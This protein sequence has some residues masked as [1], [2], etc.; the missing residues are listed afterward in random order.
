MWVQFPPGTLNLFHLFL[1]IFAKKTSKTYNTNILF[2]IHLLSII[3]YMDS[4]KLKEM[5]AQAAIEHIQK[6]DKK[7]VL[8]I[9]TGSTA[10]A[11]MAKMPLIQKQI[12]TTLASSIET[13]NILAK[14]GFEIS[15][16]GDIRKIDIYVDGADEVNKYCEMIKGLGGALT[17][18]KV[19]ASASDEFICIVDETKMVSTLGVD[20]PIPVEVIP[21]ARSFVGR[22][23]VEI[24]G[25]PVYRVGCQTDNGNII[26]DI[27][28]M[29][30]GIPS[31][32]ETILT[33][34]PG[35]VEC[36]IFAK[37][38]A[39]LVIVSNEKGV[40]KQYPQYM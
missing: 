28:N 4:E 3:K 39:N 2:F 5:V 8:G 27:R 11:F 40:S 17:R 37:R 38:H 31:D 30:I 12:T 22:E 20:K 9:G 18:E 23:I 24:G 29:K 7:I 21:M 16:L 10:K 14:M 1:K 36:G 19:L 35:V 13:Q 26:L 34:I 25:Q 6:L 15:T 33:Q 32:M